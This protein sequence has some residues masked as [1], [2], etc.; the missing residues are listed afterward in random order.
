MAKVSGSAA[1][2][3][4]RLFLGR[5]DRI[6]MNR[7]RVLSQ[8]KAM[9]LHLAPSYQT[10]A[11]YSYRLP[12]ASGAAA[13]DMQIRNLRKAGSISDYDVEIASRLARV[14]TGGDTDIDV[15]LGEQDIMDLELAAFVAL[16]RQSGTQARLQHL[17]ETGKPLRN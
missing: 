15:E 13:L 2:A 16:V 8:A 9:V 6:V 10:P 4:S 7:D 5:D 17:L 1:E 14:L 3:Q 12:G 11:P